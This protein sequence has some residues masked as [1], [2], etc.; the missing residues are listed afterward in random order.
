[1][2]VKQSGC[3]ALEPLN[4]IAPLLMRYMLL[5][6]MLLLTMPLSFLPPLALPLLALLLWCPGLPCNS[7]S[8]LLYWHS[9]VGAL[10]NTKLWSERER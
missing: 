7:P 1:M 3:F 10:S 6:A 4:L 2:S 5:L 8:L 9:V